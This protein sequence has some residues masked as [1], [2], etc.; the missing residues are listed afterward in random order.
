MA[1][2]SEVITDAL[3]EILVQAS[4]QSVQADE[5]QS[6]IRAL[7]R[8]MA[9]WD[10]TGYSLGYT[11]VTNPVDTITIPAGA[12]SAVVTNLALRLTSQFDAVANP[13]LVQAAT[14]G[15]RTVAKI[16][17]SVPASYYPDT[18]PIGSGNEDYLYE[19]RFYTEPDD[20]ILNESG[21]NIILE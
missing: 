13:A 8:M 4:E 12:I 14:M 10:A 7:N 19:D 16:A 20:E 9:E 3:Q 21:G 6:G 2:A 17:V 1:T 18:L 11:E 5:M 15:M